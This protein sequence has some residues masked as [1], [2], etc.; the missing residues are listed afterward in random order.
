MNS[1]AGLSTFSGE[2]VILFDG[3]ARYRDGSI[4]DDEHDGQGLSLR[5][6]DE[7]LERLADNVDVYD[8]PVGAIFVHD[9]RRMMAVGGGEIIAEDGGEVTETEPKRVESLGSSTTWIPRGFPR[10]RLRVDGYR[11]AP[12]PYVVSSLTS[13]GSLDSPRTDDTVDNFLCALCGLEVTDERCGIATGEPAEGA[14]TGY[15]RIEYDHGLTHLKCAEIT[16]RM[17]PA[18]R[19]GMSS[20]R[21]AMWSV[22]TASLRPD[23]RRVQEGGLRLGDLRGVTALGHDHVAPTL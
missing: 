8:L 23:F 9:G 18:F 12:A 16:I 15:L 6:P 3:R 1:N 14:N 19:D 10:P 22:D 17:C 13:P 2:T 21:M 5:S 20:A 7:E 4:D 11:T